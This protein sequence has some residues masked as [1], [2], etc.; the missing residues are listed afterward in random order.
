MS[1]LVVDVGTSGVRAS[2]VRPDATIGAV[3]RAAV[4]AR[5]PAPGMVELDAVAIAAAALD[6]ASAALE[7][8]GPV[9]AIAVAAQRASTIVWD[10]STGE[11]VGPGIGWQ[12]LRTAGACLAL[13]S[14]G[15]RVAPN[16]SATKLALLL[17]THD[18]E[19]TRD[20]CFGTVDSWLVWTLSGGAA[21]VTDATNAG[22][23]GLVLLDGSA[24]DP[25][26]LEA[27]RIPASVLPR[28]VDSTGVVAEAKALPGAPLI[29][30]I[31]GDQQGSLIGQGC[32]APGQAKA[33][34]GTG[35]MLD[36][37][38]GSERP[39]FPVKG[40]AG[41]FPIVT[42]QGG[43]T[44]HWGIE[45]IMLSAGSCVDWLRSGLGIITSAAETDALAASARDSA[46]VSFVP[47][48]GGLGTPVWDF[49]ARGTLVG[50]NASTTKSEVVRAVLE[51]IAHRGADL[52]E[53]AES[54]S[55]RTIEGL[56]VD[57]GMS[58][59]VTFVQALADATRRPIALAPV[60][61]ATTLGAAFLAG[62]AVG[63]WSSLDEASSAAPPRAVIE[64]RRRLDRERWLDAR[65][66]AEAQVPSMTAITF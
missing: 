33:T 10:R 45:A 11:P 24:W 60:T 12:D 44:I 28:I 15:I 54:D 31:V 30:G 51:G 61:E 21:H 65:S 43:G 26:M 16:Q 38:T 48:L 2:V 27:L 55:G 7:A 4:G 6:V 3:Q 46:G 63:T 14:R 57:G 29:A 66:R 20:L 13:R 59:N 22:V 25:A 5:T 64:P 62:A 1:I 53:A 39:P 47:A 41:T 18:P 42:W 19:R 9:E 36:C 17:D 58:E 34:F 37:S 35:G 23:T 49:G 40:D 32:L 52:L 8:A 56:R 50:L